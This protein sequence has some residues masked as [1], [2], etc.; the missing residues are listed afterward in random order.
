MFM[1]ISIQYCLT[2]VFNT[3]KHNIGYVAVVAT[4]THHKNPCS[5][6]VL[7]NSDIEY[8]NNPL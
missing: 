6:A 8:Y 2:T 4:R 7:L 1:V 3:M 5:F